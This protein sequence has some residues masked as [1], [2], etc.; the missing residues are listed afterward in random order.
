LVRKLDLGNVLGLDL[1]T[2][3][4]HVLVTGVRNDIAHGRPPRNG[5]VVIEALAIAERLL[6]AL[7]SPDEPRLRS[8]SRRPA[9]G[10][11]PTGTQT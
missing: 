5:T 2:E 8:G 6:D 7:A 10:P 9:V 4:E 11:K 3:K 1:G